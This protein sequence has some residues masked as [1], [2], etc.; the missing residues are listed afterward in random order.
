M[1]TPPP[2]PPS[3]CLHTALLSGITVVFGF[4]CVCAVL[5]GTSISSTVRIP[6]SHEP[7][8]TAH[9]HV[10]AWLDAFRFASAFS[11]NVHLVVAI[12]CLVIAMV[13]ASCPSI[14]TLP[15]SKLAFCVYLA[16]LVIAVATAVVGFASVTIVNDW[17]LVKYPS[18]SATDNEAQVAHG[19]HYALCTR[20]FCA[21]SATTLD[22]YFDLKLANLSNGQTSIQDV[23]TASVSNSSFPPLVRQACTAC[24]NEPDDTAATSDL[25]DW[26]ADV[27][28]G[29]VPTSTTTNTTSSTTPPPSIDAFCGLVLTD[30]DLAPIPN[31]ASPY[32]RCRRPLLAEW[33]YYAKR[34]AGGSTILAASTVLFMAVLCRRPQQTYPLA[35]PIANVGSTHYTTM[36]RV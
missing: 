4:A 21:A 33:I 14:V 34:V 10:D 19:Y 7:N 18:T 16:M 2:P 15:R 24:T 25:L 23:C 22:S 20:K 9:I 29:D 11:C 12:V 32:K 31:F 6:P 28:P 17:L 5:V 30:R 26:M 1:Q 8:T 35:P 3:T 13:A 36:N 27:C